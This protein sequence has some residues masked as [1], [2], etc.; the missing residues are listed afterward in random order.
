VADHFHAQ[1]RDHA[2][3]CLTQGRAGAAVDKIA[4]QMEQH[5]A[6]R[7]AADELGHERGKALAEAG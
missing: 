5:I 7:I 1:G 6:H 4:R 2:G 3:P